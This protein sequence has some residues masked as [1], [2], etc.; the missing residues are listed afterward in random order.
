MAARAGGATG[1]EKTPP[2]PPPH[3]TRG[4]TPR[5][6]A[7]GG[8]RGKKSPPPAPARLAPGGEAG[9]GGRGGGVFSARGREPRG[10]RKILRANPRD[11]ERG[12]FPRAR[13]DEMRVVL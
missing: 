10:E 4:E 13:R 3:C 5:P 8:G 9:R 7:R 12:D 6:R 2:P 1:E 11:G